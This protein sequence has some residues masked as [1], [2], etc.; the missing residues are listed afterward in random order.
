MKE[1]GSSCKEG[2][3]GHDGEGAGNIGDVKD[4][5]RRKGLM[6]GV[7]GLLLEWGPGL[8]LILLS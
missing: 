2:G 6:K 5:S 8:W 4:R 7:E 1:D 3:V